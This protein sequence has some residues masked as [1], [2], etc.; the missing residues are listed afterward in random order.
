[1][2]LP[3]LEIP[4][5]WLLGGWL[6]LNTI[7][8]G[9][10]PL[11]ADEAYYWMYAQQLD[12]GYFDHPPMV[13]LLVSLGKD[14][15]PGALGVRFGHVLASTA[16]VAVVWHLLNRPGGQHLWLMAAL[17]FVQPMLHVYGF[18]ATP[19]G[20]LLLFAALYLLAYRNFLQKSTLVN[21][22]LWGLTMAGLLYSKYHGLVFILLSVLPNVG[23]LI[24]RPGAWLAALGGALLYAPHLYWQYAND[25]PSFRYH[26]HGRDDVY[27]LEFTLGYV[28]NQLVIFSP[29]LVYHY[30]MAVSRN[31]PKTSFSKALRWLIIGFLLFFLFSTAKGRTEAQ[32]TAPLSIPLIYLVFTVAR[33]TYPRWQHSLWRLCLLGG[34][35]MIVARLLL[36]APREALPFAK[37]FDH[38]PWTERLAEMADD[39]PVV[40]QNSYR[41]ASL[42]TF[43][44]G[45]PAWTTSD[46]FYR[47][48]QYDLWTSGREFH[49]QSILFLGQEAWSFPEATPFVTHNQNMVAAP[50]DSF[51]MVE[52]LRLLWKNS[53]PDTLT[54]GEKYSIEVGVQRPAFPDYAI[55]LNR[56]LPLDLF[57]TFYHGKRVVS[58]LKLRPLAN[59]QLPA[60][61]VQLLY[62]GDFAAPTDIPSGETII[63]LGLGYRGMPPLKGQSERISVVIRSDP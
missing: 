15:L 48:N 29:L 59:H 30:G 24:R 23:W 33:D 58:F 26:L 20:P 61:R 35:I 50:I 25:F 34:G 42:Y 17:I 32:W 49:D 12:W 16:T 1:M 43:Y 54:P 53:L 51:Q 5:L 28:V 63:E 14:W 3:Q 13:A 37:P 46:V 10:S 39:R 11:D 40:I 7:Q 56:G 22:A 38:Q 27:Q 21:G 18:I 60:A 6:V 19:D 4:P 9:W 62:H 2:K 44:T 41:L 55:D 8:A 52:G 36:I 31:S 57:I 47:P 45:K